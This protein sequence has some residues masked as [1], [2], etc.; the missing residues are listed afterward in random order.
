MGKPL[1]VAR[2]EKSPNGASY[3]EWFA[4]RSQSHP[5]RDLPGITLTTLVTVLKHL[6][7]SPRRSTPLGLPELPCRTQNRADGCTG[8]LRIIFGDAP[9]LKSPLSAL[10]IEKTP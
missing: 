7:A 1:A 6:S 4:E 10:A 8:R 2:G 5:M 9:R 3:F